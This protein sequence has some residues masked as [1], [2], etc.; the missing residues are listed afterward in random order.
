[1]SKK[2]KQLWICKLGRIISDGDDDVPKMINRV[3]KDGGGER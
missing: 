3:K 2:A 1:M